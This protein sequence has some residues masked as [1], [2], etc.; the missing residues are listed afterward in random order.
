MLIGI[1]ASRVQKEEK[2]GT[3]NYSASII[4]YIAEIDKSNKYVLYTNK[5]WMDV[6]PVNFRVKQLKNK[7]LWTLAGLSKEMLKNSPDI[8]FIPAHV[9]PYIFPK[10]T[11]VTI[12]DLAFK[13]FP[14]AYSLSSRLYLDWST[15]FAVEHANKIIAV[16]QNTKNDL[17]RFYGVD[18]EKVFVVYHG[19]DQDYL[20]F[21]S[22]PDDKLILKK[23]GINRPYILFVGRLEPRKNVATLLKSFSMLTKEKKLSH[24]LVLV[25]AEQ[26]NSNIQKIIDRE[27]IGD[28]VIRLGYIS[29][30]DLLPI[31]S[32]ADMFV[33]PSLYEGFGFPILEAFSLGVPV[34]ASN[35]SSIPEVAGDAALLCDTSKPFTL[36]STMSRL[37]HDQNLK[38]RLI[39]KGKLQASKFS[40]QEAAKKTLEVICG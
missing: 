40:W 15:K 2:T 5:E 13:Y 4:S 34:I 6:L 27:K 29:K 20:T 8:L 9:M 21:D 12:H 14:K 24:T 16:S 22:K 7:R 32:N 37:L 26:K 3:E 38:S 28:R 25:G 23:F 36:A 10:K 11:I 17:V 35:A 18:P 1:D 33:Y 30:K 39:E 19:I 31:F